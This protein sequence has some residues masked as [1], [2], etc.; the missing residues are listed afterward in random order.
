VTSGLAPE[1]IA[2]IYATTYTM[3]HEARDA[4]I[5]VLSHIEWL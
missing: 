2:E 4:R 1:R 3:R 5:E